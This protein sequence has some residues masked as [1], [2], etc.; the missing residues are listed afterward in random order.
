MKNTIWFLY[1]CMLIVGLML[2]GANTARVQSDLILPFTFGAA[3][4]YLNVSDGRA[5]AFDGT[6]TVNKFGNNLDVDAAE[7]S[8]W[9]AD[10]L[11]SN[12]A[13]PAR[14][15]TN[16]SSTAK[17]LY[18][19]SD[20]ENDASDNDDVQFAVEGLDS[21]WDP[22]TETGV[23]LG[24]ASAGGTVFAQI[25][26]TTWLRVNRAYVTSTNAPTGN[27]YIHDDATD[28]DADGIPDEIATDTVAV[29]TAGESQTLQACYTVADGFKALMT[30][31]CI[32][33]VS[34][35]GAVNFRLRKSVSNAASR[36]QEYQSLA[37]NTSMCVTKNPPIVF[38]ERTDIELTA[39]GSGATNKDVSGT[40]DLV[41]MPE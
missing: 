21:S 22:K 41:L 13:G 31:Y 16:L 17:A 8:I 9:D 24:V 39:I 35:S 10:D 2:L 33:N 12:A 36:T 4:G 18:I 23:Q 6:N 28:A 3:A 40:F 20:D 29:I 37:A 7:E 1:F 27:I 26:T 11:N 5:H 15:W 34:G 19:S 30:G 25:G 14:C 32:G 38:D